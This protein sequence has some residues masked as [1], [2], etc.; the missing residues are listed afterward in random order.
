M[1]WFSYGGV[2]RWMLASIA[3]GE[4]KPFT[5]KLKSYTAGMLH[6]SRTIGF[7]RKCDVGDGYQAEKKADTIRS[8]CVKKYKT[9]RGIHGHK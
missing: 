7:G 3:G 6:A 5:K 9:V 2:Y 8:V 1:F 4:M